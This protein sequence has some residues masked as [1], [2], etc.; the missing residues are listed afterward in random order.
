MHFVSAIPTFFSLSISTVIY[1]KIAKATT[2]PL[3]FYRTLR[4]RGAVGVSPGLLL[5]HL[6]GRFPSQIHQCEFFLFNNPQMRDF[7]FVLFCFS[8]EKN[9]DDCLRDTDLKKNSYKL[10]GT[11]LSP[12]TWEILHCAYKNTMYV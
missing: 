5:D 4:I 11:P 2:F 10:S 9:H 3:F 6:P 1:Y 7:V 12:K 8:V